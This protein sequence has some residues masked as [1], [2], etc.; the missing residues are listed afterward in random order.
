[1]TAQIQIESTSLDFVVVD[2][3]LDGGLKKERCPGLGSQ[4][5]LTFSWQFEA[6]TARDKMSHTW[7]MRLHI[8]LHP[9][10]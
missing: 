3:L 8:H 4:G 7:P 2:G 10:S 6:D 5:V 9:S 1:M